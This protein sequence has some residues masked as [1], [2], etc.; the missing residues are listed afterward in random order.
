MNGITSSDKDAEQW[1]KLAIDAIQG[2]D[3]ALSSPHP[4]N[5]HMRGVSSEERTGML[6]RAGTQLS[7]FFSNPDLT[8]RGNGTN[9]N[10]SG[11]LKASASYDVFS[12]A[13]SSSVDFVALNPP[14]TASKSAKN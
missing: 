3:R 1:T 8:D 12:G 6:K 9:N 5:K 2:A 7:S 14:L 4:S 11:K 10:N 13:A